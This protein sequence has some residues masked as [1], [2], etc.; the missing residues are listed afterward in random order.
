MKTKKITLF[1]QIGRDETWPPTPVALARKQAWLDEIGR[2]IRKASELRIVRVTYELFNPEVEQQRKFFNGPVV[3]YYAIQSGDIKGPVTRE[4]IDRYRETM[5]SD[6]LGYE[7][8]LVNRKERRRK[9]TADFVSTQQWHDFLERL[10]EEVFEPQGYEMP[11]SEAFWEMA[12]KYGY[13][14]AKVVAI[15]QLQKRIA[16]KLSTSADT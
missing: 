6:L 4:V 13:N 15:E 5:L 12:K 7:L 3:E 14:Q 2:S 1:Y 16:A 10:R 8:E 9:S 11:D